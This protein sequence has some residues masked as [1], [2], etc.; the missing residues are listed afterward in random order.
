MSEL[1]APVVSVCIPAFRG[2]PHIAAAIES[3]LKQSHAD[4][5]LVII[6]DNSSDQTVAIAQ[7]YRDPRIRVLRNP[8]NL[9]P[10]ENWNRCLDEARGTYVKLLP[11]DDLLAS[12]CLARQVAILDQDKQQRIALVFCSRTIVD[13]SG[14]QITTRSYCGAG[15]GAIA[16]K[17]LI[18]HCLRRGTNLIGEPGSVM[19]RR[20]LAISVGRFDASIPYVLDLDYWFRL[21]L[22]GDAYYIAEDLASFRVSSSSWSVAIGSKQRVDFRRFIKKIAENKAFSARY[23]DAVSG[24]IMADI[25]NYMRLIFYRLILK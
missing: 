21:L 22:E 16:S 9:G 19:F 18:R 24:N 6:D 23:I 8:G 1:A 2:A 3:V 11:Q 17:K 12:D 13:N 10:Q 4:F 20:Q 5:E 15:T 14:R 25:N 7:R